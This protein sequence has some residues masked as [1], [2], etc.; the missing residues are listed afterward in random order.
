MDHGLEIERRTRDD[1]LQIAKDLDLPLLATNDLHYTHAADAEAHEVLLCVQ[2][3]K[4]LADPK[5]FRFDASDFYLK[6]AAEMRARLAR[7]ARGL[8]QH[9]ARS[10][11]AATCRSPR[12]P[13]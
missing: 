1:L 9:A 13:T 7:A 6:T 5:R 2:T 11:S 10:P 8:R 4:T 12:A 3:G